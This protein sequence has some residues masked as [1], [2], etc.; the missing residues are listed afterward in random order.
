MNN[1][2]AY[3]T[4]YLYS[5]PSHDKQK[6]IDTSDPVKWNSWLQEPFMKCSHDPT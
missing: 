3:K 5:M 4:L 1:L 6:Y 2:F